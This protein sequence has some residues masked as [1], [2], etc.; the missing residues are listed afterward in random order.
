MKWIAVLPAIAGNS[1]ELAER[2]ERP[3]ENGSLHHS[4]AELGH[5][6]GCLLM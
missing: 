6:Y 4:Q 5:Q 2:L 3:V 1:L